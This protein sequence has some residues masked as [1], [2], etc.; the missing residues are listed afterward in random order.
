MATRPARR[1]AK[2]TART[3]SSL[4]LASLLSLMVVIAD[5]LVYVWSDGHL[6]VA[7]LVLWG[8]LFAGLALL[9]GTVQH[10][11]DR[12][13]GIFHHVSQRVAQGQLEMQMFEQARQDP[14]AM[15]D[16]RAAL[17]SDEPVNDEPANGQPPR[18]PSDMR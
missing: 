3:L 8:V 16:L 7:I 18:D 13:A 11:S 12:L 4:V 10:W 5:R 1:W 14:R 2:F 15:A 6:V 9:S 17:A